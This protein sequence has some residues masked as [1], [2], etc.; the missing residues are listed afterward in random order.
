MNSLADAGHVLADEGTG[1]EKGP[2][3]LGDHKCIAIKPLIIK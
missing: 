3:L 1:T 2:C